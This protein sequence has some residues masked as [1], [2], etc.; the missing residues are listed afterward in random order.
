MAAALQNCNLK[1]VTLD[2]KETGRYVSFVNCCEAS[3][4]HCSIHSY[5]CDSSR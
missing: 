3:N 2:H 4:K 5:R 1:R